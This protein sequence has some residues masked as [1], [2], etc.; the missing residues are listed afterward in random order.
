M[1]GHD[2]AYPYLYNGLS[3]ADGNLRIGH[4]DHPGSTIQVFCAIIIWITHLF[5]Q[6]I[7]L[8]EDVLRNPEVYLHVIVFSQIV[9]IGF[10]VGVLGKT[11]L[12]LTSR[13]HE[14]LFAQTITL[15]SSIVFIHISRVM[16]E[17][18]VILGG[19]WLTTLVF[20]YHYRNPDD[21]KHERN[22]VLG[23]AAVAG[24]LLAT[25]VSSLPILAIPF[26]LLQGWRSK[27]IY[28]LGSFV[29]ATLFVWPIWNRIERFFAFASS[30]A[31]HTGRY[32]MGG[33]GIVDAKAFSENLVQIFTTE[34]LFTTI[35]ALTLLAT[36]LVWFPGSGIRK[37][38]PRMAWLLVGLMVSFLLNVVLTA[39][40]YSFHYLI[41]THTQLMLATWVLLVILATYLP[42]RFLRQLTST[43]LV[44]VALIFTYALYTRMETNHE[45]YPHK[46]N[47]H[48]YTA[49]YFEGDPNVTTVHFLEGDLTSGSPLPA[50]Y[51]GWAY[52]GDMRSEYNPILKKIYP[53]DLFFDPGK[54]WFLDWDGRRAPDSLLM[55][56][57]LW[58]HNLHGQAWALDAAKQVLQAYSK[59]SAGV[60]FKQIY[61]N[62]E[63]KAEIVE[64]NM[65]P[66]R[67]KIHWQLV[68]EINIDF[69]RRTPDKQQFFTSDTSIFADGGPWMC[70]SHAHTGKASIQSS[71]KEPGGMGFWIDAHRGH[72]YVLSIW[73]QGPGF[74]GVLAAHDSTGTEMYESG[75]GIK[76]DKG[77]GWREVGTWFELP[78]D[79]ADPKFRVTFW[80]NGIEKEMTYWD[81]FRLQ[82]YAPVLDTLR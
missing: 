31:T 6:G 2:P 12:R 76:S 77:N 56:G 37:K 42:E 52:A 50:H 70:F 3:L 30:M 73:R 16:T 17:P 66:S 11:V 24:W 55:K 15:F 71:A 63:T 34:Y 53:N 33:E 27:V 72:R 47:S 19:I 29:F 26:F 21:K 43:R 35:V 59:D 57:R 8:A 46:H 64:M 28:T 54:K 60:S 49:D 14:A 80:Y 67:V 51:M 1:F 20:M 62:P 10:F 74:D 69:E 18:F 81:D 65:N 61:Q 32:G 25:K 68:R 41:P 40:H 13:M 75:F 38:Q 44:V 79:F 22:I 4:T 78:M 45:Y 58:L 9:I 82:E 39:K 5:R 7:P 23:F 48:Y 36:I